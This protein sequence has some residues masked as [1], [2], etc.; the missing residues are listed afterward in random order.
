[1]PVHRAYLPDDR[2]VSGPYTREEDKDPILPN[3]DTALL[4]Y[5]KDNAKTWEPV[6]EDLPSW[7]P[8]VMTST[9]NER[10]FST[11]YP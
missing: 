5:S 9:P 7:A 2:V 4:L 11:S 8:I 6:K 3:R 10:L 1:M